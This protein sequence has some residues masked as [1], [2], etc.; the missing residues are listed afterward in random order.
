VPNAFDLA[1]ALQL[2]TD[3][4]RRAL[5]RRLGL[6]QEARVVLCVSA[7]NRYHKRIDHLIAEVA[8]LADPSV[9]LALVGHH[10]AETADV[11]AEG[12]AALGERLV[13]AS[14]EPAA[15]EDWYRA[16]DVF[17][18]PSRYEAFGRVIVEALALGLPTVI[19][20][21]ATF[22]E[23][24]GP[25]ARYVAMAR[26]GALADELARAETWRRDPDAS[27]AAHRWAYDRFSWDR[28]EARYLEMFARA[29]APQGRTR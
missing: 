2:I 7:I 10:E 29:L 15:V 9:T 21:G 22:R 27:A 4:A 28:L 19:E 3:E 6:P 24:A 20:S 17:V 23:I 14:V 16:A 8:R 13:A 1:P 12:R 5:R 18:L 25:H 11:L 26:P